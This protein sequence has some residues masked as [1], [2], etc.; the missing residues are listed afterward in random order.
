MDA[1]TGQTIKGYTIQ[2][3][4]G[5]GAFGMVYRAY[6]SVVEREVAI[7]VILPQYANQPDFVRRFE[8][9]AQLVAHLEHIHIVPLYDYW[10]D[11]SG[12]YLVMRYLRGG[13]LR[14]W[15]ANGPLAPEQA[16]RVM[17]QVARALDL[18]HH[19]AIIHRDI[20]PTNILLDEEH[21]AFL[22]DFGLA[23]VM[24]HESSREGL[25]GTPE[26]IS[27]EQVQ[28]QEVSP[29]SD[30]Y[31]LGLVLYEMLVGQP[32]FRPTNMA[33]MVDLHLKTPVPAI[34]D[35]RGDLPDT[36]N[37]VI[38]IATAK[39]PADRY[40]DALALARALRKALA[41]A[42]AAKI[43]PVAPLIEPLTDRELDVLRLMAQGL[44]NREIAEQLVIALSTV[45]WYVRQIYG[46]LGVSKRRQALVAAQH[47]NLLATE[48]GAAVPHDL[49]LP[50]W[51]V[52]ENP[53]KGL[54][55]F[56]QADAANFFGREALVEQL[57]SCLSDER[58]LNRFLAVVGP[59]GSGKSSVV[60]A[61]LL[62]ALAAGQVPGSE[63]WFVVDML[64]GAH[65][66]DKLEVALM[67]I[68]AHHAD[69]LY[70]HLT[71][72][73][74][75]LTRIADLILPDDGSELVIFI[76]QFEEVFT[77][78]D[79]EGERQQ[80]LELV[81][82]AVTEPRSRVRI[83]VTLRADY[84]DRPLQYPAIGE[85]VH[86][87]MVTVLPLSAMELER[88]IAGPAE[89]VG[90]TFENGLVAQMVAQMAHQPGAL[91]LLQYA[92]TE[93]FEHRTNR[94][95]NHAAYHQIGG[96]VGAL[97]NRADEIY[98][99]LTDDAQDLAHQ[100]FM[101][102]VTLGEGAEDTRRRATHAEVR[103]LTDHPDLMQDII[104]QFAE[105]RLLSLD[106]D[107]ESRQPTVEVAHEAI[108]RE[109][110]R[111]RQWLNASR[112][113][114]RQER[115]L[116]RAAEDW[117]VHKRDVSYLL[118]GVRLDQVETWQDATSLIQTPL[119]G[120]FVHA[121]LNQRD[122]ERAAE[123]ARQAHEARLEQRSRNFLRGLVAV[124]LAATVGAFGLTGLAF[125]ERSRAERSADEAEHSAAEF[126][127]IALTFGAQEAL[128][129]GEPHVALALAQEAINMDS[130]PPE[131]KAMFLAAGSANWMR[132]LFFAS[133]PD[134]KDA[135]YLP[136]GKHIITVGADGR[137]IVWNLTTGEE[138]Y[139]LTLEGEKLQRIAIHPDGET[140]AI[141]STS[142]KVYLWNI[143]SGDVQKL[144]AEGNSHSAPLFNAD[145][146][147][148]ITGSTGRIYIWDMDTLTLERSFEA[149]PREKYNPAAIRFNSD[150]SL[151]VTSSTG[152]G[153]AIVWDFETGEAV[154]ELN[155]TAPDAQ[156]TAWVW[157]AQFLHHD[158]WII[159]A[160]DFNIT[161]WD[162]RNGEI[163]WQIE[164]PNLVQDISLTPDENWFV[165]GFEEVGPISAQL[166]HV[167]TGT[168][169]RTYYKQGRRI[170][171]VKISPDA[172]RFV[173]ADQDGTV[174]EWPL[175]WEGAL[176]VY[177][178]P[179][180]E[181][182]HIAQHPTKPIIALAVGATQESLDTGQP[183]R[184]VY[185]INTDTGDVIQVLNAHP[186]NIGSL[187][188][189]PDGQYLLSGDYDTN[190]P[191]TQ[192]IFVW[193]WT[194]GERVS[195]F[196][197]HDNWIISMAFSPDG[198]T[199]VEGEGTVGAEILIRNFDTGE[200]IETIED[201]R[202]VWDIQWSPDGAS[203]YVFSEVGLVRRDAITGEII[204]EY[205]V[206]YGGSRILVT[207]DGERLIAA[208][209]DSST[210]ILDTET[211]AVLR[212]LD[213]SDDI[214]LS[215]D[216]TILA[217]YSW[218]DGVVTLWDM[219]TGQRIQRY[220]AFM[221]ETNAV[222]AFSHD[223]RQLISA[224]D[225]QLIVWDV[226]TSVNDFA[227]WA[228]ENR[229]IPDFTCDQRALY[230][231]E[232]LCEAGAK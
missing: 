53:Y 138:V 147:K 135:K 44:S 205:D 144:V 158:E 210:R 226:A 49:A 132:H 230:A 73:E 79:H 150:E 2:D 4:I 216:E 100:M 225:R 125:E 149:H 141:G 66:L 52:G 86:S 186:G 109:W 228:T 231:I 187:T 70:E 219:K 12:A 214:A 38:Q 39:T 200:V 202:N 229:Y 29:L 8:T 156:A 166:Y 77:L 85:L 213:A 48:P 167:E 155:H 83:V 93:L 42:P 220:S 211:G 1:L 148:L 122:Q 104:D 111:L 21:N 123:R 173:A 163:I 76:D 175:W 3:H 34:T 124:L 50:E 182:H 161:L 139:S 91:P 74:R 101:R 217:T 71:R 32:A 67:R 20:K 63:R 90:V 15:L 127:S 33:E 159:T 177:P 89:R 208:G 176:D 45:K 54:E 14:E 113:D 117:N 218:S 126:R 26:Y 204:Q 72:D 57:V 87:R 222:I 108:L 36:I 51:M 95:L 196:S 27:P 168:L 98:L 61:G 106:H 116:A 19:H 118:R 84:Y 189:S 78:V 137:A 46:K 131:A 62:P 105:Y 165:V 170:R 81:R 136:D 28:G 212:T 227:M 99:S 75:G 145:G 119:E 60:R 55:A 194:T 190:S 18:A 120:H 152:D 180:A 224:G 68:A 128:D 7:K 209:F 201:Q 56:Q 31:S 115:A 110:A 198:R 207:S 88:A 25:L 174:V 215:P 157:N 181:V 160:S 114:I 178:M 121:S 97:A 92:L 13:N 221:P 164:A 103:S 10:R 58:E 96:A 37:D 17:E 151:L 41:I 146:T 192:S 107:P 154:Q 47:L 223:G 102:L 40:A 35:Q 129:N 11:P 112:D 43:E 184:T 188:F 16:L 134:A 191:D 94:T 140:I 30:L 172:T 232:P 130:P 183:N 199:V 162:W 5:H 193:D 23:K 9:E 59:S 133:D 69:N 82:A 195:E 65:P 206:A 6:Q 185:V 179:L 24:G 203:F 80:F 197:D 143:T 64:P 171:N 22:T 153:L 142:D 169:I